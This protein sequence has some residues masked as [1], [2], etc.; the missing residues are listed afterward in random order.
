MVKKYRCYLLDSNRMAA[1]QVI[2]CDD[3]AAALIEAFG[4][5]ASSPGT[6]AEVWDGARQVSII[7]QK[8]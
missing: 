7:S 1:V 5:L 3:D 8:S 4:L 2:E 6:A